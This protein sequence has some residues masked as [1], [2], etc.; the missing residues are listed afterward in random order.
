MKI[1][2]KAVLIIVLSVWFVKPVLAQSQHSGWVALATSVQ[3]KKTQWGF[4]FDAQFRSS[5]GYEKLQQFVLRPGISY[6]INNHLKTGLGYAY[7]SNHV[8]IDGENDRVDEHRIWEQLIINH[9][10][11]R[12][13][14][15]HRFR[16]EQRWISSVAAPDDYKSQQRF[17]YYVRGV[18]PFRKDSSFVKGFY[19]AFQEEIM[20]NYINKETTN[21]SFFDQNR[22]YA[23]IGYRI[24]HVIDVEAGYMN[25]LVKQKSGSTLVNNI[26]HVVLNTRF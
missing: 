15:N 14:F 25:Q 4:T 6:K 21:N 22:A 12:V 20:F 19:G 18:L 5:N 8:I 7:A 1:Q 2:K 13:T 26:I 11:G 3:P 17:R 10:A 9:K 24:N 23:A 16:L